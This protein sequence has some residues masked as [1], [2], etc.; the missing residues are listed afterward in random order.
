MLTP[1]LLA[2]MAFGV[3]SLWLWPAYAGFT[4]VTVLLAVT[5][6]DTKLIPN[7]I[8]GPGIVVC[9]VLLAVGW[10]FDRDAG[11]LIRA[12]LGALAY[13]AALYVLALIARGGFGF[14]DVKLAFLI[15]L[16]TGF[17]GWGPVIV[18]GVFAF[19]IGGITSL[20]L[21]ATRRLTRKDS[22]PFGPF[23]VAAGLIA[24][25]WGT[26]ITDWYLN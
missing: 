17:L 6:L 12:G 20:V 18:A 13:F 3:P 11:S 22:I 21:L 5:D 14:G 2:A 7:R 25:A 16:M 9:A 24:T 19:F 15:G 1:L 4:I 10:V 23:M 8:L 26:A